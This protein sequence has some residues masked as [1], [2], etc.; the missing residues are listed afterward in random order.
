MPNRKH[1]SR[2]MKQKGL[3]EREKKQVKRLV[4]VGREKNVHVV[5]ISGSVWHNL[6]Y[7]I[8]YR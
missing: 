1:P 2:M 3:N 7:I 8:Y 5:N 6:L 4:S